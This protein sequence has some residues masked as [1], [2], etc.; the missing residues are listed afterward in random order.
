M[1]RRSAV[2]RLRDTFNERIFRTIRKWQINIPSNVHIIFTFA[3]LSFCPPMYFIHHE[4][5]ELDK[6]IRL[7]NQSV[8]R[9]SEAFQLANDATFLMHERIDEKFLK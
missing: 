9:H 6:C 7:E 1:R 2:R 3:A 4:D 5:H 8:H